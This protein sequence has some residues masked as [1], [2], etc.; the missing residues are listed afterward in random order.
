MRNKTLFLLLLLPLFCSAK[1]PGV[2]S[3]FGDGRYALTGQVEYNH[4]LTWQHFASFDVQGFLPINQHF[5]LDA[6]MQFQTV[7]VHTFAVVARPKFALPVGELFLETEVL[8]KCVKRSNMHDLAAGLSLGY[9]MDYVS[10]MLGCNT[11][12]L[13]PFGSNWHSDEKMNTEPFNLM[14]CLK[15]YC[16]PQSNP[17]NIWVAMSDFDDYQIERHWQPIFQ[18]GAH[19]DINDHWRVQISGL[20]KASGMFHLNANYY[21]A[22]LRSGISYRF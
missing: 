17:W 14:Y 6:R 5:E 18:L 21:A 20:C 8:Y 11:R 19:Y 2:H 4:N 10:V 7:N 3:G 22:N 13:A 16:R 12:V 9:R 1:D 15:I